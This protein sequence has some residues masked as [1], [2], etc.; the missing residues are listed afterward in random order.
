MLGNGETFSSVRLRLYDGITSIPLFSNYANQARD[1]NEIAF[2]TGGL[3]SCGERGLRL[4][5]R[6][7]VSRCPGFIEVI[8]KHDAITGFAGTETLQGIVHL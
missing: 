4:L 5:L 6:A 8:D 7:R 3:C 2:D 1:E